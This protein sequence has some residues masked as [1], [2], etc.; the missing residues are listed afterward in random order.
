MACQNGHKQTVDVLLKNGANVNLTCTV[1]CL[2]SP[3]GRAAEKGHT[4]IVEK[5]ISAGALINYQNKNGATPLY[6]AC[7]NGH[8]QTVDVL[9]KNGA[10]VNLTWTV[11]LINPSCTWAMRVMVLCLECVYVSPSLCYPTMCNTGGLKCNHQI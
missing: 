5:L 8:K 2:S 3:L 9:L 6:A 10:N 7:Q 11:S 1:G 4:E